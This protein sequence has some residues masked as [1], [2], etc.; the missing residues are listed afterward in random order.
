MSGKLPQSLNLLSVSEFDIAARSSR[1]K[2]NE[3]FGKV[4]LHAGLD[5]TKTVVL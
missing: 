1:W 2:A 3:V 5:S 4:L